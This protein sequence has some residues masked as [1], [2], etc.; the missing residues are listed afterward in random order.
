MGLVKCGDADFNRTAELIDVIQ[1]TRT[2]LVA[3][4]LRDTLVRS[5]RRLKVARALLRIGIPEPLALRADEFAAS[6]LQGRFAE[7]PG[8][9][10]WKLA[11]F[12]EATIGLAREG[13]VVGALDFERAFRFICDEYREKS[14]ALVSDD[15]LLAIC[16]RLSATGCEVAVVTDGL[17]AREADIL[18]ILFP[19][20]VAQ[21]SLF[22]SS[23][24][25]ANKFEPE[26]YEKL[27]RKMNVLTAEIMVIGNRVDKDI[28]PARAV[29]CETCLVGTPPREGYTGYWAHD[30]ATLITHQY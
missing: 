22:T 28:K 7:Q 15:A 23:Q 20:S 10:D 8:V 26:F 12:Y 9:L 6:A 25:G 16:Q 4:D 3:F 30:T 19:S 2:R 1:S 13:V 24:A 11:E 5:P 18:E 27:A 29:G 17:L 14:V 21:M